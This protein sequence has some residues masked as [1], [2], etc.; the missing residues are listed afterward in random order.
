MESHK[1]HVPN[2]QPVTRYVTNS[3]YS[4]CPEHGAYSTSF[5]SSALFRELITF[6]SEFFRTNHLTESKG[7]GEMFRCWKSMKTQA[8]V[9]QP[10]WEITGLSME[11]STASGMLTLGRFRTSSRCWW[12]VTSEPS[13]ATPQKSNMAGKSYKLSFKPKIIFK[14]FI[15]HCHVWLPEVLYIYIYI[16]VNNTKDL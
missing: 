2:H 16:Y 15:V 7:L 9:D 8:F 12:H 6:I 10:P 14:L 13:P 11:N 3:I 1:I 5:C 4:V